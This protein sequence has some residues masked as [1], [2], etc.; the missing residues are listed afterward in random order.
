MR[1]REGEDVNYLGTLIKDVLK[2][3]VPR[4]S[5]KGPTE[6]GNCYVYPCEKNEDG[7]IQSTLG[8]DHHNI[9]G[10]G[11]LVVVYIIKGGKHYYISESEMGG[12]P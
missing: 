6:L 1:I 11:Y 3:N 4:W 7:Q 10:N 9:I 2:G 8:H 12:A 5:D